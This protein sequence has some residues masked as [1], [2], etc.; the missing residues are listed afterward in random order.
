L[1]LKSYPPDQ[2]TIVYGEEYKKICRLTS[3]LYDYFIFLTDQGLM[4]VL[5]ELKSGKFHAKDGVEQIRKGARESQ[6]LLER[7]NLLPPK[8]VCQFYPILLSGRRNH[9]T[10]IGALRK[11]KI[12]FQGQHCWII[13][14][15]CGDQLRDIMK[16]YPSRN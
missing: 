15:R 3:K 8:A 6:N 13:P 14:A 7:E 9:R 12:E 10:E 1:R 16:K 2:R 4:V 11:H 5:V